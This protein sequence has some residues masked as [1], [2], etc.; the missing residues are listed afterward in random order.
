MKKIMSAFLSIILLGALCAC[1]NSGPTT[2]AVPDG[3]SPSRDF[4][5]VV[6][7]YESDACFCL[8]LAQEWIRTIVLEDYKQ[9]V[10]AGKLKYDEY[11]TTDSANSEVQKRYD[12]PSYALYITSDVNG[13]W[14][15]KSIGSIWL[16]T[17]TT[18]KNEVLKKKFFD[19]VK[20]ELDASLEALEK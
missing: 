6:S 5:H 3:L 4:V 10:D 7:F 11:D 12:S 17:D 13:E 1:S 2:N 20:K 15:Y 18:G 14:A 8:N 16:Y 19:A 9:Y